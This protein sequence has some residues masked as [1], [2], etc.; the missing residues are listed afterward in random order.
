MRNLARFRRWI[1]P[2]DA[3]RSPESGVTLIEMM[4]VLVIIGIVAAMIVPNV[5]GR[6]DQARVAVA[7]SDLRSIGASLEMYRL[8]NRSYP[9]TTQGLS[10]LAVRPTDAP[11]PVNWPD[12][13]YIASVPLDPWGHPFVYASPGATAGYDLMSYGA[14]GKP[15]GDGVDADIA[16]TTETAGAGS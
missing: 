11:I 2:K 10:A 14:D 8:D 7:K 5:I 6:P 1:R 3:R 15:G 16:N 12:G 13:G 4:I 9:T